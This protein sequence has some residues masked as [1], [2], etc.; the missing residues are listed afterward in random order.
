MYSTIIEYIKHFL[1]SKHRGHGVHSPFVFSF[2]KNVI[3]ADGI[4]YDFKKIENIRNNLL[5]NNS[6]IKVE[7]FGAGSKKIK[8]PYRKISQIAKTSLKPASQ[9]QLLFR[10]VNYF[11]PDSILELGTSL[12]ITTAYLASARKKIK[13]YTIEGSPEISNIA[14]NVFKH[15]HLK[16]IKL[17]NGKFDNELPLILQKLNKKNIIYIDG[18]H[19][20]NATLHYF[21]EII[22]FATEQTIIIFDDIYW[23]K[24]MKKAWIK[25]YNSEKISI[26][27][28]L[29]WFGIVFFKKMKHKQ[30][31][32]IHI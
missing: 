17:L 26:S 18:N 13:I 20:Y 7:D 14:K 15:L 19:S 4:F 27:I 32:K 29:F 25:I 11:S 23:S 3:E 1:T 10:I 22:K 8:T 28:D 2:V 30:H 9:A 24:E 21:N 12:G 5:T 16:N 31:F 6:K